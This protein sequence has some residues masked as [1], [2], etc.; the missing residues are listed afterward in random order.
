MRP[1]TWNI[2]WKWDQEK[3]CVLERPKPPSSLSSPECYQLDL[4]LIKEVEGSSLGKL[5]STRDKALDTD[6][7]GFFREMTG[8]LLD[9]TLMRPSSW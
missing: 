3:A 8:S 2:S 5:T 1:W 4:Y 6:I 7:W 9:H